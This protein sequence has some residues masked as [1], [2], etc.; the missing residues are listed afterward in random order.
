MNQQNRRIMERFLPKTPQ[1]LPVS[2]LCGQERR[3][4]RGIPESFCPQI[5]CEEQKNYR[6]TVYT[7]TDEQGL[8]LRVEQLVYH[9]YPVVEYTAYMTNTAQEDSDVITGLMVFDGVLEGTCP[10][11]T[12]GN[13]DTHDAHG[14]EMHTE[15]LLSLIDLV[16]TNG[17][18]SCGAMPYF[19]LMFREYG[20]NIAV[21]WPG[22]W[23]AMFSPVT[24]PAY[25][26]KLVTG[27][28]RFRMKIHPGETIRTPSV[29][30]MFFTGGESAGVNLWRRWYRSCVMPKQN[31]KR[32]E[33]KLALG[34][35]DP[36]YAE[37]AGATESQQFEALEQYTKYGIKPDLWW[38][39]AG[40][41]PC[42]DY[43]WYNVGNW[44]PNPDHFPNGLAPIGEKCKELGSDFLV[45]FEPERV[46]PDTQV[47]N[48]HPEWLL[49][50]KE[51]DFYDG[52]GALLY[53]GNPETVAWITDVVDKVIK[54]NHI[55]VYRQDQN[56]W[57]L[58]NLWYKN[59]TEFRI[60]A[61]E[62]L[63]V[64]GYLQ[65]WDNL[66]ERNPGLLID[67]CAGGGR[68]NDLETMKRSVPLH[69]TDVG[70]GIHP[71]KQKQYRMMHEWI[72]YFRSHVLDNRDEN[73]VYAA[74]AGRLPDMFT[75]HCSLA[76]ALQLCHNPENEEYRACVTE[77]IPIW[78]KAA[79]LMLDGDYYPL[80]QCRKST[81][82]FYAVQFDD[83]ETKTGF[84][85][86]INNVDNPEETCV[87]HPH[88][89]NDAVYTF[90]HCHTGETFSL[91][92]K[93]AFTATVKKA[94]AAIWFY[95]YE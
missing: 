92:G 81:R 20:V 45:W 6:K 43:R 78:R 46:R 83:P 71:V 44:Y 10:T 34:K 17:M 16:P 53:L 56:F 82:D 19:R 41:Y 21:G 58:L 88:F 30:L 5:S 8:Q 23:D 14:Y 65:F 80:T 52:P 28:Y 87:L 39:D 11:L 57:S 51:T 15:Q 38:I 29:T 12:Y 86:V 3:A 66:L 22:Q 37:W 36:K 77:F 62:N 9:D 93:E 94:D 54:E 48:A 76:P 90:T 89:E 4:V 55:T 7:G 67:A 84:I 69:Y 73:N 64:Q 68:R 50:W 31:G 25:G 27:Q 95:T 35:A 70:Y 59:E 33:P 47:W 75:F 60:G 40:W 32:L 2:Y 24:K 61:M 79:R 91:T 72:P 63:H 74:D 49:Y 13:G 18:G 26:A 1:D 42:R 85:Q